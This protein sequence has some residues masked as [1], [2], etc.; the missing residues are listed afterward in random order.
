[1][2]D[3]DVLQ[4]SKKLANLE[5]HTNLRC[6]LLTFVRERGQVLLQDDVVLPENFMGAA[7][8]Q[9]EIGRDSI[10]EVRVAK[11]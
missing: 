11:S 6:S 2:F 3:E 7:I 5:T 9:D 4:F 10:M 8:A 1:M